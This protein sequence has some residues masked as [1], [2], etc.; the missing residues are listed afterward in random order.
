MQYTE[1]LNHIVFEKLKTFRSNLSPQYRKSNT[2]LNELYS[3][4]LMNAK[5]EFEFI[6]LSDGLT[7]LKLNVSRK[8][9]SGNNSPRY[10]IQSGQEYNR[11]AYL[12]YLEQLF[13]SN[14][15]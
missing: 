5:L 14:C 2:D 8:Y 10:I 13:D 11:E 15:E 1:S 12:N 3:S 4:T 7:T 6:E 9:V